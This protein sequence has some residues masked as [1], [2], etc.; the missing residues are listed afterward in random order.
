MEPLKIIKWWECTPKEK[1]EILKRSVVDV[2]SV[3]LRTTKIVADVRREGDA[4]LLHYTERFD[5]VKLDPAQ[6]AVTEE[7]FELAFQQLKPEIRRSL[8]KLAKAIERFHRKQLPREWWTLIEKGVRA[9]QLVRPL[10]SVG[11]YV[12]GGL[13]KYPS[14]VLMAAIPAR[15]AGV[16][17]II[18]CTPPNQD[19]K[20]SP[21]VLVAARLAGVTQV[22]KAG[23]A[24]AVAAMAYGTE[25]IPKVDKIVGPGNVYVVAAKQIVAPDVEVDFAAGPSEVLIIAD[26]TANPKFAAADLVAQAEHDPEAAAVLVTT[27]EPLAKR[28]REEARKIVKS[29]ARWN[30]SVRALARYGRIIIVK[31]LDEAVELANAYAP[32]H[33]QLMVKRPRKLLRLIKNAGSIF[34]GHYTPVAAGDLGVGVNHILPTGGIAKR[35]SGLSVL[36]FLKLPTVQE[37]TKEGLE[38]IAEVVEQL[39]NVEGLPGHA[40]SVR[41]RLQ[42]GADGD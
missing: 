36:H 23:G 22:F 2:E 3:L 21:A 4:A 41:I 32:E 34:V 20:I 5:K 26:E 29:S 1:E 11:I 6:L 35:Q 40:L 8:E 39:A 24:Q 37:L 30:I 9:G 14:T 28:V 18:M 33:L 31:T 25:T 7:E 42:E 19:G 16:K 15:I 10:E 17:Q 38:S 13:A 12:P 27:S